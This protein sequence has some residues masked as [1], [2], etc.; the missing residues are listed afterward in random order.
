MHCL[1]LLT[2]SGRLLPGLLLPLEAKR[3]L[4][5]FNGWRP[6]V[7]IEVAHLPAT[8]LAGE[9][10]SCQCWLNKMF[11]LLLTCLLSMSPVLC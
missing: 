10:K 7:G 5:K 9:L 3:A 11:E 4:L 1:L 2:S 8:S 6:Q